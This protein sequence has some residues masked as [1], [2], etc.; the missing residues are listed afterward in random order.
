M[1]TIFQV[2]SKKIKSEWLFHLNLFELAN[3]SN[4]TTLKMEMRW[5]EKETNGER[6]TTA[7]FII[8]WIANLSNYTFLVRK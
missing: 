2:V 7:L 3:L 1:D 4:Y 6:L 8:V 5:N